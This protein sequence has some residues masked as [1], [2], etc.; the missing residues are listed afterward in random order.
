LRRQDGMAEND[1]LRALRPRVGMLSGLF[2]IAA[3]IAC[4]VGV[5]SVLAGACPTCTGLLSVVLPWA[6]AAMYSGLAFL[7]WRSPESPWLTHAMGFYVFAHACLVT[8]AVLLQR[9]CIGCLVIAGIALLSGGVVSLRVRSAR[10]TLALGLLLGVVAGLLYPFDRLE[11]SLTRRFW[12]S[13]I[14]ERAPAFADRK[15]LSDCGHSAPVRFIVYED[16][17]TCRSCSSVGRRLIPGL[18]QEFPKDVCIHKHELKDPPREQIL[19]VILLM[20]RES[21]L[22]VVE[23]LPSYEELRDLVRKLLA[24]TGSSPGPPK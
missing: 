13:R 6:G 2:A 18:S 20:S 24:E 12:P 23:G 3:V 1:E 9:V 7:A 8:E 19:P 10:L 5:Q 14:L 11:D 17:R 15:E 4:G 21:R 22:V 16:E